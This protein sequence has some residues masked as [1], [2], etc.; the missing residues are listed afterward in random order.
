M[1]YE[2]S[3]TLAGVVSSRVV[4]KDTANGPLVKCSVATDIIV[5]GRHGTEFTATYYHTVVFDGELAQQFGDSVSE[6]DFIKVNGFLRYWKDKS[7]NQTK[8]EVKCHWY[9]P[10]TFISH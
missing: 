8:S 1:A 4:V 7:T 9:Q 6:G 3:V 10:I 5:P 2:N